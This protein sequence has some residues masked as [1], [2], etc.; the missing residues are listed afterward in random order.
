MAQTDNFTI[1]T[2]EKSDAGTLTASQEATGLTAANLLNLQ[3]AKPWRSTS[4]TPVNLELDFTDPQIVNQIY[5]GFHNGTAD[6]TIRVRGAS[7]Q[8]LLTANPGFDSGPLPMF[9]QLDAWT[10]AWGEGPG[11]PAGDAFT[12]N[13]FFLHLDT[14]QAFTWWRLDIDD[15]QNTDGFIEAGRLVLGDAWQ[16]TQ[17]ISVPVTLGYVDSSPRRQT[18]TRRTFINRKP[19]TR[20]FSGI[21][22]FATEEEF[23]DNLDE[24]NRL[25]MGSDD[26]LLC[27]RPNLV[28][29]RHKDLFY[30][31][32]DSQ[33]SK[34]VL[35]RSDDVRY[36]HQITIKELI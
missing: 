31:V 12:R 35:G 3:P 4:L 25:R 19:K 17:N 27:L 13:H 14:P 9:T 30:G 32:L 26:V 5:L 23:R 24:I 6:G 15:P 21:I 18:S 11:D 1:L 8:A 34:I 28:A 36:R 29:R 7:S 20:L 2:P 33:P 16:S 10:F 22:N